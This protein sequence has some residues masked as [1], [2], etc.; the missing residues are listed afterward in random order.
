MDA[1]NVQYEVLD[2]YDVQPSKA[3]FF[4]LYEK[5]QYKLKQYF[6]TS[7]VR[8]RELG[9]KDKFDDLTVEQA[10]ELLASDGKLIKRPLLIDGDKIYIGFKKEIW[11]EF[12]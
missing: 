8:Y 6:N 12:L 11:Q 1:N 5:N 10:F 7:G 3:D 9:I 2:I 4:N